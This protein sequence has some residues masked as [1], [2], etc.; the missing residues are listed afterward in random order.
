MQEML[1]VPPI[2]ANQRDC[3]SNT[4][5]I[6]S[7]DIPCD[8]CSVPTQYLLVG[9]FD[10]RPFEWKRISGQHISLEI[11]SYLASR[12]ACICSEMFVFTLT[13]IWGF[14]DFLGIS[15][16]WNTKYSILIKV[17][18]SSQIMQLYQLGL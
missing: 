8:F 18:R 17:P 16:D 11:S 2:C 12:M 14:M 9:F 4:K 6:L 5:T 3:L 15:G 10:G 1:S 7:K 13:G